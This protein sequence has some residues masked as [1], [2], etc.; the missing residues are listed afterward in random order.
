MSLPKNLALLRVTVPGRTGAVCM[1]LSHTSTVMTSDPQLRL[2]LR[3][4]NCVNKTP[5]T[6]RDPTYAREHINNYAR[7]P[8]IL[9]TSNIRPP[10][11]QRPRESYEESHNRP[12]AATTTSNPNTIPTITR[13]G[14]T[15]GAERIRHPRV[16]IE[17]PHPILKA[18]KIPIHC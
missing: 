4:G 9:R 1:C 12:R 2:T 6:T 16:Q 8:H 15:K 11:L 13:C 14:S 5:Y 10:L 7:M 18:I 17:R 3:K